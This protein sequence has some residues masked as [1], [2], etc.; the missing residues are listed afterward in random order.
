MSS[1]HLITA[2][3]RPHTVLLSNHLQETSSITNDTDLHNTRQTQAQTHP[4]SRT[5]PPQNLYLPPLRSRPTPP[6]RRNPPAL[7]PRTARLHNA[8]RPLPLLRPRRRRRRRKPALLPDPVL[9]LQQLNPGP[10][11]AH[12]DPCLQ[13]PRH[14]PRRAPRQAY[15]PRL[16]PARPQLHAAPRQQQRQ[17][18]QRQQQ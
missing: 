8:L 18:W 17:Q 15:P 11:A 9:L 6:P 7:P 14:R 13:H 12:H 3:P 4:I 10:R 16:R 2:R 5:R 1:A